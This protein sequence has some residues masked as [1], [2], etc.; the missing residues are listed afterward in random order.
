[1]LA[2]LDMIATCPGIPPTRAIR[3]LGM[4]RSSWYVCTEQL[5]KLG[6]VFRC[7][8][9]DGKGHDRFAA[10]PDGERAHAAAQR[11]TQV[12][13]NSAPALEARFEGA[14]AVANVPE[15]METGFQLDRLRLLNGRDAA[16][17]AVRAVLD[18]LGMPSMARALDALDAVAAGT[19]DVAEAAAHQMESRGPLGEPELVEPLRAFVRARLAEAALSHGESLDHLKAMTSRASGRATS[20]LFGDSLLAQGRLALKGGNTST[21]LQKTT[22][23]ALAFASLEDPVGAAEAGVLLLAAHVLSADH[24]AAEEESQ[25]AWLAAQRAS[26]LGPMAECLA[27]RIVNAAWTGR[28][29]EYRRMRQGMS[30]LGPLR[31]VPRRL[32]INAMLRAAELAASGLAVDAIPQRAAALRVS[33]ARTP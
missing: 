25:G 33:L 26:A 6:L 27:L 16:G 20:L 18:R 5:E 13:S 2:V 28:S 30:R 11:L 31:D 15:V 29:A 9:P 23:A 3:A 4:G 21:A 7:I 14:L 8:T 32:R 1:M 19:L 17:S 12:A 10:S 24:R 22:A